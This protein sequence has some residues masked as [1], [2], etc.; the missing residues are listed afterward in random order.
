MRRAIIALALVMA[1]PVLAYS[2]RNGYHPPGECDIFAENPCASQDV[3]VGVTAYGVRREF[4]LEDGDPGATS[5]GV[6]SEAYCRDLYK[7]GGS[8]GG[9]EVCLKRNEEAAERLRKRGIPAE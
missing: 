2:D 6:N 4:N 1:T 5:G 8:P 9:L 3:V 7:D